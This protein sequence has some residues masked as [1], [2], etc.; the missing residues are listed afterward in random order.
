MERAPARL[1]SAPR[2][3]KGRGNRNAAG[4]V[5][6]TPGLSASPEMTNDEGRPDPSMTEGRGRTL[7]Y[8]TCASAL[9]READQQMRD[10]LVTERE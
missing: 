2:L 7:G 6:D 8:A 5:A 9:P 1:S 10:G 3:A 4:V